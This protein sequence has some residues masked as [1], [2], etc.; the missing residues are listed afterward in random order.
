MTIP[1]LS[2]TRRR[3][4]TSKIISLRKPKPTRMISFMIH[5][6]VIAKK[7]NTVGGRTARTGELVMDP[8]MATTQVSPKEGGKRGQ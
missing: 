3:P 5:M 1:R 6:K 8:I 7:R 4:S 2:R